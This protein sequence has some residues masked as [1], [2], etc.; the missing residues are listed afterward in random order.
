[1]TIS[2]PPQHNMHKNYYSGTS[3]GNYYVARIATSGERRDALQAGNIP[4][5][6][7]MLAERSH[8]RTRSFGRKIGAIWFHLY[9]LNL[10]NLESS[11]Q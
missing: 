2:P 9:S 8:T 7:V 3:L 5:A 1:M 4:A 6:R 10:V 11:F